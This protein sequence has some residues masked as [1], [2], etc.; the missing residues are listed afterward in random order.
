M[1]FSHHS[2]ILFPQPDGRT[3][4]KRASRAYAY[5]EQ[6]SQTSAS[7]QKLNPSNPTTPKGKNPQ[8]L[9][10][11]EKGNP[12]SNHDLKIRA[13]IVKIPGTWG[14]CT[15]THADRVLDMRRAQLPFWE[16]GLC[17]V[18]QKISTLKLWY[19]TLSGGRIY[20]EGE[21]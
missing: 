2:S 1:S 11:P 5:C 8:H 10:T 12:A 21:H 7:N 4:S 15:R 9:P 16:N 17:D 18:Q 20:L 14:G 19:D 3:L 13:R 6:Y